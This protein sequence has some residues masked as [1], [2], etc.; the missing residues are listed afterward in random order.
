ML[1]ITTTRFL[2]W[3]DFYISRECFP[4]GFFFFFFFSLNAPKKSKIKFC[5]RVGEGNM[6]YDSHFCSSVNFEKLRMANTESQSTARRIKELPACPSSGCEAESHRKVCLTG[7]LIHYCD[8]SL[9]LKG[10][11]GRGVVN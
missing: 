2:Y 4:F 5:L 11:W 7:L 1:V 8:F 6:E 9:L 3:F 10:N